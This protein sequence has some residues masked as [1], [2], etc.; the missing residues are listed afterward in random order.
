MYLLCAGSQDENHQTH[1]DHCRIQLF[2]S[3][4][5]C[6]RIGSYLILPEAILFLLAGILKRADMFFNSSLPI[7]KVWLNHNISV[8]SRH[9]GKGYIYFGFNISRNFNLKPHR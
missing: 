2:I 8:N 4:S 6:I 9:L 7:R 1:G 5:T 3:E